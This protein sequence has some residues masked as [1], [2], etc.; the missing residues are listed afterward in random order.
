ME[1]TYNQKEPASFEVTA[2]TISALV[3]EFEGRMCIGAGTVTTP[4]LV[5]LTAAAGGRFVI[6]PDANPQVIQR[7]LELGMVSIPGALTPTEILSAHNAGADFV[8]LFPVFCMGPEYAQ[9]VTAPISHVKLLAVGGI[10]EKNIGAYLS[11]GLCGA[12]VSGK[13]VNMRWVEAGEY[14]KITEAARAMVAAVNR[15]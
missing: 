11:A 9:A 1:V 8:K 12:G 6:S 7:T 4:A 13:L 15:K 5:E 2:A 3:R 10:T 14:H